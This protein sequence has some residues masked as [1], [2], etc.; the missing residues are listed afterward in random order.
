MYP[1]PDMEHQDTPRE[2]Y[3]R[4]LEK[5][6]AELR[7]HEKTDTRYSLLRLLI[8]LAGAALVWPVVMSRT[9][10]WTWMLLPIGA[11]VAAAW[12][13]D[14]VIRRK[15]AAKRAVAFY[16]AGLA[17]IDDRWAGAGVT[18]SEYLDLDHAYAD[19]L[20]LFGVGSLFELLCTARTRTGERML[21][22]WLLAPASPDEV[23]ERQQ[24][25]RE[26]RSAL[27][28]RED[29]ARLGE[30]VRADD[31]PDGLIAWA[32]Q[33]PVLTTGWPAWVA[34]ILGLANVGTVAGWLWGGTGGLPVVVAA[35][36]SALFVMTHGRR[37]R[38]VLAAAVRPEQ[39]LE[40]LAG[41]LARLERERFA[42]PKLSAL[43]S[44]LDDHGQVPSKRI[45]RLRRLVELND[46]RR[47]MIFAPVAALMMFGTQLAYAM[48]RWRAT[49]GPAVGRWLDAVGQFEALCAIASRS[50]EHPGEVF[51]EIEASEEPLFRGE[52][53][54]HPL[55]LSA[56][57]VPNDLNLGHPLQL[58]LV[59]GSNMSG[60]STL[61]RTVGINAV[62]AQAG[63]PVRARSLRLSP[64]AVGACLNVRDSL[65]QGTSHFYAEI[66][67]LRRL[68][69]LGAEDRPLLF[70][71]D[72]VL[73]GTNS[74]DRRIG[75]EAVIRELLER[76][77]LGLVTT[78]DL[79]L[80]EIASSL[81]PRASN[82][83]FE[84][85]L[86]N[87]KIAFDYRLKPGVVTKSNA[88]ELMRSVGLDV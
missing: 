1:V 60:K 76:G 58:L 22:G 67:R 9:L 51:P 25:A 7:G 72:E 35:T 66:K 87:G 15:T 11:F 34:A 24:S 54:G 40:L 42:A 59:S 31:D 23:L 55:L 28:L 82:V 2:V 12:V 16:E 10:S 13:H 73:H 77:G 20:D 80:A 38:H 8:F 4:R 32:T 83:H 17:R 14:R 37:V 62:L 26:L 61:L 18:G 74:H 48:E 5:R 27:D 41:V 75:A 53:I 29:L 84:D 45:A 33:S 70:L 68:T 78:H 63:A 79:A 30:D 47:N 3:E 39:E 69:D 81:G 64:L 65:Q 43:R 52:A 36:A 85:H 56:A 44:T 21:A 88:L 46:S 86:E 50:F 49:S 71:L 19:D 6:R 57:C